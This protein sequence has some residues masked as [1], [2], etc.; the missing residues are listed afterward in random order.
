LHPC[1]R[2]CRGE[3]ERRC[4][5]FKVQ[6][7]GEQIEEFERYENPDSTLAALDEIV[8]RTWANAISRPAARG[9]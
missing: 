9:G 4:V 6:S 1:R 5:T 8:R 7:G 2:C 3:L